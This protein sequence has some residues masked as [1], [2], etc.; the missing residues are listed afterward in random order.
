MAHFIV[1]GKTL[2]TVEI[3][4]STSKK[5]QLLFNW[6]LSKDKKQGQANT[7]PQGISRLS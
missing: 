6:P 1:L 2:R 5:I 4:R 3:L 7:L